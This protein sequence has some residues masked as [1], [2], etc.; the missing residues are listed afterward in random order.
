MSNSM[1]QTNQTETGKFLSNFTQKNKPSTSSTTRPPK[2]N[3]KYA[4][5]R[6]SKKAQKPVGTKGNPA[7]T[8]TSVCCG[9]TATKK[10]C[11]AVSKKDALTQT[12]GKFRCNACK[13]R[14]KVTVSK[15]KAPEEVQVVSQGII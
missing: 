6:R 11:T 14:C 15:F 4:Q 5:K 13:K 9:V 1:S 7:S 8:Y 2:G 10:P 3:S 12:L